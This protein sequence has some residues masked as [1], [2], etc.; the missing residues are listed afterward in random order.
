MKKSSLIIELVGPPG[1]GKT[2]FAEALRC[3]DGITDGSF[4]DIRDI[5]NLAFFIGNGF[6]L[7]PIFCSLYPQ[8]Y[9]RAPTRLEL[10]YMIILTGWPR[11]LKR[12]SSGK[13][14]VL[15]LDQGPIYMMAGLLQ[16][17]PEILKIKPAQIWWHQ[18]CKRWGDIL[19][20]VICLDAPDKTLMERIREREK[21]HGIKTSSDQQATQ[22]LSAHRSAQEKVVS[23][24]MS[25]S[26]RLSFDTTKVSLDE[27]IANALRFFK[28]IEPKNVDVK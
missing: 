20:F 9:N 24:L 10:A 13:G 6:I 15:I 8:K 5:N 16:S 21:Q 14:I 11:I 22:Y 7:L 26:R 23:A 28:K 1:A 2:T 12:R 3:R 17:H 4:P 27:M 18:S 19:D 25:D